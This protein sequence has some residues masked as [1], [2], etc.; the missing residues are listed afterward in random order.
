MTSRNSMMFESLDIMENNVRIEA[1]GREEMQQTEVLRF[2]T[3]ENPFMR[4]SADLNS[5]LQIC[6]RRRHF[7]FIVTSE[8][9]RRAL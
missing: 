4:N 5:V 2:A 9:K 1:M 7:A 8:M 3:G 6:R